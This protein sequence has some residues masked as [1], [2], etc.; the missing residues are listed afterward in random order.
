MIRTFVETHKV[1]LVVMG[2]HSDLGQDVLG[3]VTE[4]VVR[5]AP[6]PVLT[7]RRGKPDLKA[8][9]ADSYRFSVKG[10]RQMRQIA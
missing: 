7:V 9:L 1:D 5:K 4:R 2:A 6:C 3:I 8:Y 10:K